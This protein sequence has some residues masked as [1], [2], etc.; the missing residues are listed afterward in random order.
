MT[1]IA[2]VT[3]LAP[4]CRH[5]GSMLCGYTND[6]GKVTARCGACHATTARF[7]LTAQERR[8]LTVSRLR[9]RHQEESA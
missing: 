6:D 4:P 3:D 1:T 5:C 9:R 7:R 8:E 2:H